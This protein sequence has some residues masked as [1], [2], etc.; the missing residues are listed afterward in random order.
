ML[1]LDD[2]LFQSTITNNPIHN[3]FFY[4][5]VYPTASI[6]T[7]FQ[8]DI[9]R[10]FAFNRFAPRTGEW[11]TPFPS[12]L[13]PG[14]E[15]PDYDPT[16]SKTFEEVTDSRALDIK[17]IMQD[18][19]SQ[20]IA[21]YYSGG[22]DSLCTLVALLKCL[23]D[24]E[25]SRLT[26]CMSMDSVIEYP[27]FY[28]KYIKDKFNI[29]DLKLGKIQYNNLFDMGYRVITADSGDAMFGTEV[30]TQFYYSY[31]NYANDLSV[32]NL[33]KLSNMLNSGVTSSDVHYSN[34]ADI[35]IGYFNIKNTLPAAYETPNFGK[36]YYEKV[37]KLSNTSKYPV[38]SLH[39]FFW[40]I[41]FNIKWSHCAFRGPMFFGE[42]QNLEKDMQYSVIN[43]YNTDDYQKWSMANNNT[44]EKIRGKTAATYKWVARKYIFGFTKDPWYFH[45]KIKLAS[46]PKIGPIGNLK[47]QID[48]GLRFGV[49]TTYEVIRYSDPGV[50]DYILHNLGKCEIDW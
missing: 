29:I 45:F 4:R 44:G 21:L 1:N 48:Q 24:E 26:L 22:M 25:K 19:L 10:R 14:H 41:I 5:D 23:N 3:K 37:V 33:T 18:D 47:Q 32:E 11:S 15:M 30:S 9:A 35:I 8:I 34:F 17:K 46:L 20:K 12:A 2:K 28:N 27:D 31:K 39:D 13:M 7:K 50:R 6:A 43:W 42:N 16:F 40:Q 36:M 49:D 38:H